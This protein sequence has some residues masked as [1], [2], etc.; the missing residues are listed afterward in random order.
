MILREA[1]IKYSGNDP[2]ELKP[3]SRKRICISCDECGRV[4]WLPKQGYHNLCGSCAKK[5]KNNGFYGKKHS[6]ETLKLQSDVKIGKYCGKNNP[7][8][9]NHKLAGENNPMYELT[10]ELNPNYKGG[11]IIL[12]CE[13]CGNEYKVNKSKK[14]VSKFCSYECHSQWRSINL[15]GENS[16]T[17]KGGITIRTH[18]KHE[19]D[20]IK[21]NERFN[22]S[23]FHHITESIGIYIPSELHKH[24]W[25]NFKSGQ[26][27]DEM[28]V[29]A[30]QFIS[31]G[32]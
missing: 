29:L 12:I 7:N 6:K 24:I 2:D 20:C 28:N 13:F 14:D 4:R 18:V 17:W 23:N 10:G 11:K 32:L 31:G 25:H 22:N 16:P 30:L 5:G 8:Y 19:R 3:K 27:M 9:R 26:G 15:R 21:L 1:T